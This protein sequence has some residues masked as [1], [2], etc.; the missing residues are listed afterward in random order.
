MKISS[1]VLFIIISESFVCVCVCVC[2]C[3]WSREAL[4]HS[5]VWFASQRMMR[6][7]K[8]LDIIL[9]YI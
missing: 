4:S 5:L 3:V 2:V 8:H 1:L 6:R 7:T 9:K